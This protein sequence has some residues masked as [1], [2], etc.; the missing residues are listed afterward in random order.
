MSCISYYVTESTA[1]ERRNVRR[2]VC[3]QTKHL[4]ENYEMWVKEME[5]ENKRRNNS[6]SGG[7]SASS[8][9]SS[10]PVLNVPM[11]GLTESDEEQR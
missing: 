5:E 8:D 1:S 7:T 2:V 11:E 10:T 3:L 6:L 9:D 4:Q